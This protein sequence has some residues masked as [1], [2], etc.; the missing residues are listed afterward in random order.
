MVPWERSKGSTDG[1]NA[2]K[3]TWF[4]EN[5]SILRTQ[6]STNPTAQSAIPR[7]DDV[8]LAK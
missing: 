1:S 3:A 8:R 7:N 4:L 2:L 5:T 6:G